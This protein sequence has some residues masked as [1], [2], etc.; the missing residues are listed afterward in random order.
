MNEEDLRVSLEDNNLTVS[1]ER[2]LEKEEK[3]ENLHRMERR[4]GTF[5]RT[6]RLPYKR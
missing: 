5:T 6:F 3:E 2:K 1:G 4:Y